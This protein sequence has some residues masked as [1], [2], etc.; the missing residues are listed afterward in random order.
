VG[1]HSCPRELEGGRRGG[2][3]LHAVVRGSRVM[4]HQKKEDNEG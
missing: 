1:G 2:R 3:S 4:T